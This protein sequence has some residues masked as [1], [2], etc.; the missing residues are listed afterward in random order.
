[1]KKRPLRHSTPSPLMVEGRGEGDILTNQR[2]RQLRL[3]STDAE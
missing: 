1:M 2:A 3:N